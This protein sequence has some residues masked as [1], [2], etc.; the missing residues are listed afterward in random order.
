MPFDTASIANLPTP[1]ATTTETA[2]PTKRCASC[3]M[4]AWSR[5]CAGCWTL[6]ARAALRAWASSPANES[7]GQMRDW[8]MARLLGRRPRRDMPGRDETMLRDLARTHADVPRAIAA[9][10]DPRASIGA[11]GWSTGTTMRVQRWD[12]R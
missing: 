4:T 8:A 10:Y 3:G 1:P 12:I 2:P 11:W 5:G 9:T 6:T 7:L